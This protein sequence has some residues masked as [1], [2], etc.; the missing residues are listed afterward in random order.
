[1]VT[2]MAR[3]S[4]VEATA[5]KIRKVDEQKKTQA[6]KRRKLTDASS[7]RQPGEGAEAE[8]EENDKA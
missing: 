5:T 3:V 6:I 1:M 2:D 8:E 4:A 7:L